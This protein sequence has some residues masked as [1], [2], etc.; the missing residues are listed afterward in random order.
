MEPQNPKV[1]DVL[2]AELLLP[3]PVLQE[4]IAHIYTQDPDFRK[5]E[6]Q[7]GPLHVRRWPPTFASLVRIVLGQQLSAKAAMAIFLRVNQRIELTPANL[8][9]CP[10]STL[11]E[12]GFSQAKIATCKRLAEA[13]LEGQVNLEQFP[14]LSDEAIATQLTQIKGIGPWTAQIYLLFCLER[15]N[16]FPALDL[17]LQIAYQRLKQMEQRPTGREFILLCEPLEPFRGAAAH[18][19]WHYYRHY[20]K[21]PLQDKI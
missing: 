6:V 4:A 3:S 1:A 10:E 11:K 7:V 13:V 21:P 12:V 5:I 20:P 15:L 14:Q 19:L 9:D 8:A 18:L 2:D 16:S 17:A